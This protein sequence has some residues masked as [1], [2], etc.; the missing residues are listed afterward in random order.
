MEWLLSIVGGAGGVYILRAFHGLLLR[1]LERVGTGLLLGASIWAGLQK[2]WVFCYGMPPESVFLSTVYADA[3]AL[4]AVVMLGVIDW[5]TYTLPHRYLFILC[6]CSFVKSSVTEGCSLFWEGAFLK[7]IL[8][9]VC[10]GVFWGMFFVL[11]KQTTDCLAKKEV[12]GWGDVQFFGV[13][14]LWF[15]WHTGFFFIQVGSA[16]LL[17]F[18]WWRY[19]GW[20]PYFPLGPGIA[21]AF[22]WHV[23]RGKNVFGIF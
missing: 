18:F 22:V 10:W 20:G 5:K 3:L 14:G 19:R 4:W 15:L 1:P 21:L 7:N 11:F 9:S 12:L 17:T 6:V 16:G 23:V 8:P 2:E 13:C